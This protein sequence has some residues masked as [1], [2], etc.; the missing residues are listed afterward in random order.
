VKDQDVVFSKGL[1]KRSYLHIL[2]SKPVKLEDFGSP[3][4]RRLKKVTETSCFFDS[5]NCNVQFDTQNM[6]VYQ[7]WWLGMNLWKVCTDSCK[8]INWIVIIRVCIYFSQLHNTFK[9]CICVN[10]L[11]VLRRMAEYPLLIPLL[12]FMIAIPVETSANKTHMSHI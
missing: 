9:I 1:V 2:L 4:L 3:S 7:L 8:T 6:K 12:Q 11:Y 5:R 10:V